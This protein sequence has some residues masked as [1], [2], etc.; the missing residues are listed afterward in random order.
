MIT[1]KNL[2]FGYR[3]KRPIYRDLSLDIQSGRIYGL[4]GPNGVGKSTLLKLIGGLLRPQQGTLTLFGSDASKGGVEMLSELAF[5]PE[6]F[7]LPN[8]V[9]SEW[10]GVTAPFYPNF[11]HT[12]F[13]SALGAFEV[14]S[15][16]KFGS[17]SM[18]QRKKVLIAFAM[19]CSTQLL[20]MDEP[21]N[22]LDIT[23][24]QTFR[25]LLASWAT[26]E[27]T[28]IISTHQ[29]KDV[30]NLLD[31]II[32]L[33]QR[34]VA[35]NASIYDISQRLRFSIENTPEGAIYSQPAL[36]GYAVVS[37]NLSG[38]ESNVEIELLYAA[39]T[40]ERQRVNEILNPPTK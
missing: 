7:A 20:I 25:R 27:R 21:T 13:T 28:A 26:P 3:G 23:S 36:G 2:T 24:K 29:V 15:S 33:D 30:E 18:G 11:D 19:A 16:M 38:E 35:C 5:L 9:V 12:F 34:G 8:I 10:V 17:M 31:H 4:L 1:V 37:E 32:I 6:E 22:G 14:E 40:K 39:I